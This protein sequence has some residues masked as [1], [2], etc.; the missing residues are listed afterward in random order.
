MRKKI[1]H[2]V[3]WENGMLPNSGHFRATEDHFIASQC[4][5]Q[6]IHL[7]SYNYGLLRPLDSERNVSCETE[8]VHTV[9]DTIEIR[10]LRCFGITPGGVVVDY[11]SSP[12]ESLIHT[13]SAAELDG[14]QPGRSSYLN[15]ILSVSPYER[16]LTGEPDNE[17][18]PP[19]YPEARPEYRL[20][21]MPADQTRS[22]LDSDSLIVGRIR[23]E[24]NRYEK[25]YNY[26]PP[27]ACMLSDPE[28]TRYY[29]RFGVLFNSIEKAS[30]D[31]VTKVVN[32]SDSS[33]MAV[34]IA[35]ICKNI[36]RH[37]STVYFDYRNTG[38]FWPPIRIVD[39]FSRLAHLCYNSLNFMEKT[40]KEDVLK[41][42]Y[43]WSDV[44]PKIFEGYLTDAIEIKYEHEEIR[45][46]MFIVESFLTNLSELWLTL[47]SL[48]YIGKHKDNI[49]V[50][51][52]VQRH[53]HET[54]S[55]WSLLD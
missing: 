54:K 14:N 18:L 15:I 44:T 11:E 32:R 5:G 53:N 12:Q 27:C 1:P 8:I 13:L 21:T 24:G 48:D 37:T 9:T 55:D 10:L 7:T 51:E 34:N 25:D 2:L 43:E 38:S 40:E 4:L 30:K 6:E 26:I 45:S 39:C 36:L 47:S 35:E 16:I 28:L 19:R 42:F 22:H 23:K 49:V 33:T 3:N 17:E 50:G 41:Y 31:I 20:Y 52:R 46:M 29:G